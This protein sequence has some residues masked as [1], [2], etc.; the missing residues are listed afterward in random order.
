MAKRIQ[1]AVFVLVAHTWGVMPT[2]WTRSLLVEE[3]LAEEHLAEEHLVEKHLVHL[4]G[5]YSLI[6]STHP[7][8]HALVSVL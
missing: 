5:R 4:R 8:L 2:N 6:R 7:G 3:H 1:V